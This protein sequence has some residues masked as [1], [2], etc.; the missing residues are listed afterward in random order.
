MALRAYAPSGL[1]LIAALVLT[2]ALA[3]WHASPILSGMYSSVRWAPIGLL[4]FAV[5]HAVW[6]SFRLWKAGRGEGL[7]CDCG[8]LLGIERNGRYG[9]YRRCLACGRNVSHQREE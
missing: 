5:A 3:A 6:I 1:S 7:L 9:P 2:R 8:G 4:V